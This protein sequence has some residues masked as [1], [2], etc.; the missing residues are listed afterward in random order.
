MSLA[1]VR[2]NQRK[3]FI[4]FRL[5]KRKSA[6]DDMFYPRRIDWD[7]GAHYYALVIRSE[8]DARRMK[9]HPTL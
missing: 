1:E 2:P 7:K 4:G 5:A 6:G 3:L 8:K 9:F